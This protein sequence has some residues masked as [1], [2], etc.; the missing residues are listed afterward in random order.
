MLM[1]TTA[2]LG[3]G[4]HGWALLPGA[5]AGRGQHRLLP[6]PRLRG[7]GM[8]PP[9]ARRAPRRGWGASKPHRV[10][11]RNRI[12]AETKSASWVRTLTVAAGMRRDPTG[13]ALAGTR[14]LLRVAGGVG[15]VRIAADGAAAE[16]P[17]GV[18]RVRK[19]R[20]GAERRSGRRA[21]LR[22]ACDNG[23]GAGGA[24]AWCRAV[25]CGSPGHR[26]SLCEGLVHAMVGSRPSA[27]HDCR[28]L[29]TGCCCSCACRRAECLWL[30]LRRW[31]WAWPSL[32]LCNL[33]LQLK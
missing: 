20:L 21:A 14:A 5:L 28:S 32:P 11:L 29:A 4:V 13:C 26:L 19:R 16:A 25:V 30:W 10:R 23:I 33:S 15:R 1:T 2:T 8:T 17:G 22:Q 6:R 7:R 27:C 3:A 12:R 9:R 24:A 31:A 18:Q